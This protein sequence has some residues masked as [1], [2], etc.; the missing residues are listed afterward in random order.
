[1]E[2]ADGGR[3]AGRH[4]PGEPWRLIPFTLAAVALLRSR[5]Y[6]LVSPDQHRLRQTAAVAG[7][8]SV[9][10]LLLGGG[11]LFAE[12]G[13]F[14]APLSTTQLGREFFAAVAAN[15]G[16]VDFDGPTWLR[17]G[18]ALAAGLALIA[19]LATLSAAAPPP[20]PADP[21]D[22]A[23]MRALIAHADADTLAPFAMRY[24][25]TY[26]FEPNGHAA[27]GYRVLAGMAV[28]G[29]DPIGARDA[30][31]AAIDAF[32]AETERH[33]GGRPC[34]ARD[35]RRASYGPRA[36]CGASASATR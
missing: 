20:D 25:K 18:L 9:T 15:P 19:V 12:R 7:A 28:A 8:S 30:W 6:F 34:S 36:R 32:L 2:R 5:D 29:G 22:R 3:V 21:A 14:A 35:R 10:L 26:I 31:P 27:I 24:D 11:G 16:R 13:R 23:T 17:P 4:T 33:G 1:M